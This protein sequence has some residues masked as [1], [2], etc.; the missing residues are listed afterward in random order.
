MFQV[1]CWT[2]L[3]KLS[4][5]VKVAV[6]EK[7]G[8]CGKDRRS[9]KCEIRLTISETCGARPGI[10]SSVPRTVVGRYNRNQK[11]DSTAPRFPRLSKVRAAF[12]GQF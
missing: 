11:L 9:R 8:Q 12:L 2:A 7:P 4:R 1:P 5:T 10:E 6:L 3:G